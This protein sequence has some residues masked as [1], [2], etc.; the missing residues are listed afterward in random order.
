MHHPKST[1][2]P[3]AHPPPRRG[4]PL[5]LERL[6]VTAKVVGEVGTGEGELDG[7]LEEAE[8]VARVVALAL[9][10]DRVHRA[11]RAE[12]AQ[13]VGELDL[14]AL[15]GGGLGENSKDVGREDVATNDGEIGGRIL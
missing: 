10:L 14:A 9:E 11:P 1:K 8:L 4:R 2:R 7:G 15:V 12:R 3:S 13:A 5:Q 6:Q